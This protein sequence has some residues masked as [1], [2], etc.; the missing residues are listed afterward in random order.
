MIV[1]HIE[2][3]LATISFEERIIRYLAEFH[4]L[5]NSNGEEISC[6]FCVP[7]SSNL[8]LIIR[9]KDLE[10]LKKNY[11]L[12][13]QSSHAGTITK[14]FILSE[15]D[16]EFGHIMAV[17][18]NK[19]GL[20]ST[21]L[22]VKW[23]SDF[24]EKGKNSMKLTVRAGKD[25]LALAIFNLSIKKTANQEAIHF[26]ADSP[27]RFAPHNGSFKNSTSHQHK[28]SRERNND[29]D[30]GEVT[31]SDQTPKKMKHVSNPGRPM[32]LISSFTYVMNS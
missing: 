11:C 24:G 13:L 18:A 7:T 10:R 19:T 17:N 29:E 32:I 26:S 22:D 28:L 8:A 1:N 31:L 27:L 3:R 4:C 16:L 20:P 14:E 12:T 2:V 5:P 15:S 21:D 6:F 30:D 9:C 25:G 23:L